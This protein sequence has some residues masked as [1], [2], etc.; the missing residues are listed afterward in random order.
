[1][2]RQQTR[3]VALDVPLVGLVDAATAKQEPTDESAVTPVADVGEPLKGR[4]ATIETSVNQ[5]G[6]RVSSLEQEVLGRVAVS[7]LQKA[8]EPATVALKS[9][10]LKAEDKIDSLK[11]R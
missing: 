8:E 3:G 2:G 6:S 7:L 9:R 11:T 4:V 10:V 1:M 5:L